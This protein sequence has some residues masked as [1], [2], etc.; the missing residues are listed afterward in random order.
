MTKTVCCA[1]AAAVLMGPWSAATVWADSPGPSD[2]VAVISLS[3]YNDV[4]ADL[5]YVGKLSGQRFDRRSAAVRTKSS[6][7]LMNVS[8]ARAQAVLASPAQAAPAAPLQQ[9]TRG[10]APPPRTPALAFARPTI[11][12]RRDRR[13]SSRDCRAPPCSWNGPEAQSACGTRA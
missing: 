1:V 8:V 9:T 3:G 10:V 6:P 12:T 2:P 5:A 7:H 11:S 13:E 4:K